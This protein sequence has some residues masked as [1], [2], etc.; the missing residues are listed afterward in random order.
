MD[1]SKRPSGGWIQ[2]DAPLA[3]QSVQSDFRALIEIFD[4]HLAAL[5]DGDVQAR[6]HIA[7]ARAAAERGLRLSKELIALMRMA[8]ESP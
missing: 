4:S 1:N 3:A 5:A 7:E 6:I 8:G 2:D